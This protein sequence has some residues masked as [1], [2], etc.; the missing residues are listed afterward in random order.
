M[1]DDRR[2][3]RTGSTPGARSRPVRDRGAIMLDSL[4]LSW[5]GLVVLVLGW[6]TFAWAHHD[7]LAAGADRQDATAVGLGFA[8]VAVL[9]GVGLLLLVRRGAHRLRR[10]RRMRAWE[11][12]WCQVEPVWSGRRS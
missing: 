10:R 3:P 4:V 7:S 5:G 1:F 8:A 12:E 6:L 2:A 11:T 9:A